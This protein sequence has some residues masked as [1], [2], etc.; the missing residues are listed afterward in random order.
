MLRAETVENLCPAAVAMA[1]ETFQN[2]RQIKF[3]RDYIAN[4]F[5]DPNVFSSKVYIL[6]ALLI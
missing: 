2:G 5:G 1:T 3:S 4:E 6:D